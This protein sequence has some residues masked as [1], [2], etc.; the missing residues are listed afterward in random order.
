MNDLLY[1]KTPHKLIYAHQKHKGEVRNGDHRPP[2]HGAAIDT[3]F[4]QPTVTLPT[5]G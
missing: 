5:E 2:S 3:P 4:I 1:I